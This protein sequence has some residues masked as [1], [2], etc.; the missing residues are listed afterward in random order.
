MKRCIISTFITILATMILTSGCAHKINTV[1]LCPAKAHEATELRRIA[2]SDFSGRG[3]NQVS[4][5]IEALLVGVRM[6]GDPYFNVIERTRLKKIMKEQRLHLTGAVDEKTAVTVG[7]LIGAEGVIFGS[8]TQSTV[9]NKRYSESR[10][11]CASKNK[12][13]KC[14][15]WR[16]YKVSCTKRDA[17]YSFTPKVVNV[18]TGQIVAS[19]ILTG[20]ATDSECRDSGTPLKGKREMIE[21]AKSQA[22]EKFRELIAPYQVNVR[23]TLLVSDDSNMPTVAKDKLNLGVKWADKGRMD[24]ACQLWHEASNIHPTGYAI[25][26]LLG[27]CAEISGNKQEALGYY[28]KADRN[29]GKP[30]EEINEALGRVRVAMDQQK[31][32]EVQLRK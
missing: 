15:R 32:L 3:G 23:I 4:S 19:E 12:K 21:G 7:R 28:E 22:L 16:D 20:H 24:R 17:Y 14:T 11:K 25:P 30:V 27:V 2:V 5:D 26:Y 29:T 8:V 9:E 13:G 18:A 6:D 31:K 1:M 10:S